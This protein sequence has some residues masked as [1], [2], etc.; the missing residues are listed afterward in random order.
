VVSATLNAD[1]LADEMR[2][3]RAQVEQPAK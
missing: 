1:G 2:L 3:M